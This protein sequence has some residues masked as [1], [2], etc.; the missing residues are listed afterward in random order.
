MQIS[1]ECFW[2]LLN[3]KDGLRFPGFSFSIRLSLMGLPP[4]RPTGQKQEE[5]RLG[6]SSLLTIGPLRELCVCSEAL[7]RLE[8]HHGFSS[9]PLFSG[10]LLATFCRFVRPVWLPCTNEM[11][12]YTLRWSV[13]SFLIGPWITGILVEGKVTPPPLLVGVKTRER[14]ADTEVMCGKWAEIVLPAA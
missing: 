6:P 3:S 1:S 5:G 14:E 9:L 2:F 12:R 8:G 13:S 11:H 4:G 7:G 10:L